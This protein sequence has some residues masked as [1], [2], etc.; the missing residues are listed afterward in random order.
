[1]KKINKNQPNQDFNT[2]QE[3]LKIIATIAATVL[4][5]K[6]GKVICEIT[7]SNNTPMLIDTKFNQEGR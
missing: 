1:M 3:I 5:D 4:V 7:N 6:V 2:A